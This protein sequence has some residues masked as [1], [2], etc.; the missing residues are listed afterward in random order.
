MKGKEKLYN[1]E[2]ADYGNH[3]LAKLYLQRSNIPWYKFYARYKLNINIRKVRD[4]LNE[5]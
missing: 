4:I 1:K 2:L 5:E 3:Q